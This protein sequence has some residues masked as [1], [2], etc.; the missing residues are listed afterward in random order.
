M[1]E[2]GRWDSARKPTSHARSGIHAMIDS[3]TSKPLHVSTGGDAGPYMVLPFSQL[4]SVCELLDRH[5][6][7]YS[8][9]EEI[10]SM[11]DEPETAFINFGRNVVGTAVQAILDG[12]R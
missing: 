8:V 10:I 5:K 4:A 7:E 3:T 2:T 11:N 12:V 9:A 1:N 6:I